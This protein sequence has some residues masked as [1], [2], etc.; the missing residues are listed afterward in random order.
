M[1]NI[2]LKV[3]KKEELHYRKEWMLDPDTMNYNAGYDLELKGYN[4]KNGTIYKSDEELSVWYDKWIGV[5]NK[6][7]AFVY[8][9]DVE[10]PIGEVYYYLDDDNKY[11]MGILIISKYR[12]KGY[13]YYVLK[14]L[15]RVAFIDN[16]INELI[17]VIPI[18]RVSA[19]KTFKRAGFTPTN[20]ISYEKCFNDKIRCQEL[21]ITKDIFYNLLEKWHFSDERL[22]DLVLTGKK[23]AT[24]SIFNESNNYDVYSIL[25]GLLY[26]NKCILKTIETRIYK[27]SDV[28][29]D[30]ATL[31]GEGDFSINYWKKEHKEFFSKFDRNFN[32]NKLIITEIFEIVKIL[33]E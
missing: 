19:I 1:N 9:D 5:D 27:F 29:E 25:T 31:E 32:E 26:N 24:S 20:N 3:P 11:H 22:L 23:K 15:Q 17:D 10:E 30:I 16:N 21:L 12:G 2:Y 18:N 33:E 8:I 13:S 7:L 14:E 28:S 4:K 6:Y